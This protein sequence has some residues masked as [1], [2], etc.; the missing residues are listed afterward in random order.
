MRAKEGVAV[1]VHNTYKNNILECSYI[2]SR[3]LAVRIRMGSKKS[4][5]IISLLSI[6]YPE[7]N[8]TREEREQ[9]YNQLQ[10]TLEALMRGQLNIFLG[11]FNARV[12]DDVIPGIEQRF[13]GNTLN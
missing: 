11:D 4:S 7:Y 3:I 13:N 6:Q 12:G 9:F 1:A 8:K 2:S 10:Q 5:K